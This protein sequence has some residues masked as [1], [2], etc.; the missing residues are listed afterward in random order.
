MPARQIYI[1][2]HGNYKERIKQVSHGMIRYGWILWSDMHCTFIQNEQ[3]DYGRRCLIINNV[4]TPLC[5]DSFV[6]PWIPFITFTGN[7]TK[8]S[9]LWEEPIRPM[10]RKHLGIKWS[11]CIDIDYRSFVVTCTCEMHLSLPHLLCFFLSCL[12]FPKSLH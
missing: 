5:Q 2:L 3:L 6:I 4:V 12:R 9:N 11:A 8:R 1:M 7:G 10:K